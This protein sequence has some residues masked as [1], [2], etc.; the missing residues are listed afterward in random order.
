MIGCEQ[1]TTT[2]KGEQLLLTPRE[3][4]RTLSACERT[5]YGLTKSGEI[6]AVRF[7]PGKRQSVRYDRA[8]LLAWID[9]A[10][11]SSQNSQKNP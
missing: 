1:T 9:R 5:L 2:N 6:P 4:A 10:K 11:K 7:G 3:A 8:D